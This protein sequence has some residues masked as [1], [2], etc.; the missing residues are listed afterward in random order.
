MKSSKFAVLWEQNPKKEI[1]ISSHSEHNDAH[2]RHARSWGDESVRTR[3][4]SIYPHDRSRAAQS[5][6]NWFSYQLIIWVLCPFSKSCRWWWISFLF[7]L[8]CETKGTFSIRP[9]K[10]HI[11]TETKHPF[12][13]AEFALKFLRHMLYSV[14]VQDTLS[15]QC[16]APSRSLNGYLWTDRKKKNL[17]KCWAGSWGGGNV[18]D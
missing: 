9:C 8:F 11:E 18:T 2:M 10:N 12:T 7:S 17:K 6:Y 3:R 13:T 15:S 1:C 4:H 16:L 5:E 14:L